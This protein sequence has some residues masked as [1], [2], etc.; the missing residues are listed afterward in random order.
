M[1]GTISVKTD[2][3]DYNEYMSKISS[4]FGTIKSLLSSIGTL[5]SD[6]SKW[7]GTAHDKCVSIQSLIAKYANSIYPIS[8]SFGDCLNKLMQDAGT[9]A[10][11]SK[12]VQSLRR[13]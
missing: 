9:F 10:D 6:T 5:L 8:N 4:N 3:S 13:L 12:G 2:I 7:S 11:T 1:N